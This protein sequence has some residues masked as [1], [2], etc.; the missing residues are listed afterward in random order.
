MC[1][2]CYILLGR[3]YKT[4]LIILLSAA[5][6]WYT[7]NI[8]AIRDNV[9]CWMSGNC[10]RHRIAVHVLMR[11]KVSMLCRHSSGTVCV[12]SALVSRWG[13]VARCC[14][15]DEIKGVPRGGCAACWLTAIILRLRCLRA[16]SGYGVSVCDPHTPFTA[17]LF[18][19]LHR[20]RPLDVESL[21]LYTV[22]GKIPCRVV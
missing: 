19:F 7:G 22:P 12:L 8:T 5:R 10:A 4:G 14:P 9:H 2:L 13:L 6:T 16:R 18:L 17:E 1:C 21:V 11:A 3:R 20:A 15:G